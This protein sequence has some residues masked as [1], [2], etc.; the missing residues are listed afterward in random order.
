MPIKKYA[1]IDIGSNATRLIINDLLPA[2]NNKFV[3]EKRVYIRL[4]LRIGYD[5]FT[6]G[7]IKEEM[8]H[9]FRYAMTIFKDI[10]N[11]NGVTRFRAC[12]T[13]AVRNAENKSEVVDYIYNE[14]GIEIEIISGFEEAELLYMINREKLPDKNYYI[15][16][17]MGGGS[18][19]LAVFNYD[20]LIWAHAYKTGTLRFLTGTVLQSEI[21]ALEQKIIDLKAMYPDA[22]LM[23]SGGNINKIS[24]I[25]QNIF[26]PYKDMK[27]LYKEMSGLSYNDRI[28]KYILREDRADVIIPAMA[29]YL[30]LMKLTDSG[31]IY[32]PKTGLADGII[33][34]LYLQDYDIAELNFR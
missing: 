10:L 26:V 15:S 3:L 25:M 9:Q 21:D 17:E 8:R 27:R 4:P 34:D 24:K 28:R 22:K 16:A 30:R 2:E 18:L 19:Q 5:V 6:S 23:G 33:R 1:G 20:E 11:Y 13:S 7:K 14:T 31:T 12:A 29:L 32:I